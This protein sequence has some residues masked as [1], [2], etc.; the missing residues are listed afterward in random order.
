MRKLQL[1]FLIV[2]S[3]AVFSCCKVTSAQEYNEI[4]T[5]WHEQNW[6][7][8][9]SLETR[10]LAVEFGDT[11]SANAICNQMYSH[12]DSLYI[13]LN[14]MEYPREAKQF[15]ATAKELVVFL[16]DST[17]PAFRQTTLYKPETVE[18][19]DSWRSVDALLA[20]EASKIEDR[21]IEEQIKFTEKISI[22]Y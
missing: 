10:L 12:L 4:I 5:K 18:W 21:L 13:K 14:E 7:Y 1:T 9:D 11:A 22:N 15:H 20:G 3:L 8:L 19:Y 17:V 2:L 6:Q 16:R